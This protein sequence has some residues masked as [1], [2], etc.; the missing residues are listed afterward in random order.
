[1][2]GFQA[3]SNLQIRLPVTVGF[4][5]KI[6]RRSHQQKVHHYFPE[7]MVFFQTRQANSKSWSQC[8]SRQAGCY[9]VCHNIELPY[10]II[11]KNQD[12]RSLL[13]S[14]V[15]NHQIR[16]SCLYAPMMPFHLI[17]MALYQLVAFLTMPKITDP[18]C[19]HH[20]SRAHHLP[21]RGICRR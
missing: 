14:F 18:V 3:W 7:E 5:R 15:H 10:Q 12:T 2:R 4:L 8:H 9:N 17:S 1:M 11:P 20:C 16:K 19:E 6:S 13:P 21:C